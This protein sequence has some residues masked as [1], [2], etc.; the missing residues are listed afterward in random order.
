M[1]TRSILAT[2]SN[3]HGGNKTLDHKA[4]HTPRSESGTQSVEMQPVDT[5]TFSTAWASVKSTNP[6]PRD[7]PV[8]GSCLITQSD[9]VPYLEKYSFT[10]SAR[11]YVKRHVRMSLTLSTVGASAKRTKPKPRDRLVAGSVFRVQSTTPPNFSK[12]SLRSS[13][14][15]YI[16][17]IQGT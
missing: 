10:S 16:H 3:M 15:W 6:K 5:L 12:Y 7:L 1:S 4:D 2:C 14:K 13:A 11:D 9:T 8:V 17:N